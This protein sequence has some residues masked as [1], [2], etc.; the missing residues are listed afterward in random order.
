MTVT[1]VSFENDYNAGC[2]PDLLKALVETNTV[3]TTGY[4]LDPY[5][6]E[7]R[8]LI[9]SACGVPGADVHFFVGGTQAN[10]T[11]IAGL[12]KPWQGVLSADTGHINTHEAGAIEAT[13]HKVLVVPSHDGL[14]SA[15]AIDLVCRAYAEDPTAEHMVQPGMIYLSHPTELGTIYKKSE[16]VA[17]RKVADRWNLSIYIDGARLASA[18]TAKGADLDL[19][20]IAKLSDVFSIGGTKCGALFGEAV[21]INKESL[22][23]DFRSLIKQ[24]GGLLAKGR[25]IGLQFV[26]LFRDGL[27]YEIG[28]HANSMAM[29]LAEEFRAHQI[30]FF[31]PPVSNQLFVILNE[32]EAARFGERAV[33]EQITPFENG[34]GVFRFVTSYATRREQIDTL[35]S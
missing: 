16:L 15:D 27:Y 24:R 12:L 19:A 20:S 13:G 28:K 25:L 26:E 23:Q 6:D 22:K 11:V 32:D 10:L 21:V 29:A 17:I 35:F 8:A 5:S 18:L 2:H 7:A 14:L 30:E 3:Q 33:F 9:K 4:G 1:R 31:V 34:R